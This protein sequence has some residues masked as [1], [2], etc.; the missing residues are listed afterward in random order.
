MKTHFSSIFDQ[1]CM[2]PEGPHLVALV[3]CPGLDTGHRL[4]TGKNS[5]FIKYFIQSVVFKYIYSY[6]SVFAARSAH[7]IN[8]T[9]ARAWRLAGPDRWIIRTLAPPTS[10]VKN[11]N[12][13]I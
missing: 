13:G 4:W 9:L 11:R 7:P 8:F 5:Q 2:A 12:I 3:P 6:W 10:G 1:L